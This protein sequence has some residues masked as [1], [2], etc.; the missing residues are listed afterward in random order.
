MYNVIINKNVKKQ[1]DKI[2]IAYAKKIAFAI[3][4]LENNPRP[5]G[6]KKLIGYDDIYR[7]RVGTYRVIYTI[8]DNILIVEIIK[9]GTRQSIYD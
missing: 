6:C 4:D 9:I 1:L 2:P 3:Y 5:S 8:E 7:I